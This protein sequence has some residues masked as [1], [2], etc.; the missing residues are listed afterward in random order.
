MFHPTKEGE[1][2][3]EAKLKLAQRQFEFSQI[4][5]P[6]PEK[7][8]GVAGG[9]HLG[10]LKLGRKSPDGHPHK[11]LLPSDVL[12]QVQVELMRKQINP[13]MSG[14]GYADLGLGLDPFVEVTTGEM[15]RQQA[16]G[17]RT[18]YG[19]SMLGQRE[20]QGPG[21]PPSYLANQGLLRMVES[22]Y[23]DIPIADID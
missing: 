16:H 12:A 23:G 6:E 15:R 9:Q 4:G 2:I 5:S 1:P 22:P 10:L 8:K 21:A 20:E 3:D 11:L 18:P 7:V 14:G 13:R 17:F 19:V